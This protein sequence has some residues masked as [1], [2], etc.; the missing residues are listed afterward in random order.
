MRTV[1]VIALRGLLRVLW[2]GH[3]A[4]CLQLCVIF[5]LLQCRKGKQMHKKT[6]ILKWL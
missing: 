1:K 2:I 6:H 5:E 4:Q 3:F